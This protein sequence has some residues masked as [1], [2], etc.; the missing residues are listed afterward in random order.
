MPKRKERYSKNKK[1]NDMI[2]DQIEGT[3]PI[4]PQQI[5]KIKGK[6]RDSEKTKCNRSAE[7][8]KKFSNDIYRNIFKYLD[9]SQ[10]IIIANPSFFPLDMIAVN[11]LYN[12]LF[13]NNKDVQTYID[14]YYNFFRNTAEHKPRN[15]RGYVIINNPFPR[16]YR[17]G[18]DKLNT[19]LTNMF[20]YR[21]R[22]IRD[23]FIDSDGNE[24]DPNDD[25]SVA[26][27]DDSDDDDKSVSLGSVDSDVF[28][29]KNF[30]TVYEVHKSGFYEIFPIYTDDQMQISVVLLNV[31]G[32]L[33]CIPYNNQPLGFS[34][35]SNKTII[36]LDGSTSKRPKF[37][38]QLSPPPNLYDEFCTIMKS[39]F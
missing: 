6:D 27:T 34:C 24:I 30:P 22:H 33:T 21:L 23:T 20:E 32:M 3:V 36:N 5:K 15:P 39:V 12:C 1:L 25:D 13:Y 19:T 16:T 14:E 7:I 26:Y 4:S 18:S 10:I 31:S 38:M 28:N 17:K 8:S 37:Q 29:T 9:I 2:F 35:T 11:A